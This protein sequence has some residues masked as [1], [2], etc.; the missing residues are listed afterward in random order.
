MRVYFGVALLTIVINCSVMGQ[1]GNQYVRYFDGDSQSDFV[2]DAFKTVEGNVALCG[3]TMINDRS[4]LGFWLVLTDAQQNELWQRSYF[5][6][7]RSTYDIAY[8][9]IQLDDGGYV[10]GGR[11]SIV[12]HLP[13]EFSVLRVDENGEPIW[14]NTYNDDFGSLGN[15]YAVI[16][17]KGGDILAVGGAYVDGD[18]S[19]AV[20]INL[21]GNV[22]WERYFD[23]NGRL[24]SVREI[25]DT[26]FLFAG[27]L[28]T[29]LL[30]LSDR[31]GEVIWRRNYDNTL[32]TLVSSPQG[33]YA[34]A[35]LYDNGLSL[36]RINRDGERLW[37]GHYVSD[38]EVV[39]SVAGTSVAALDDGG[40]IL[41]GTAGRNNPCIIR[42]DAQGNES[43]RRIDHFG[44]RAGIQ[45]EYSS[46]ITP[47]DDEIIVVGTAYNDENGSMDGFL[48]KLIPEIST[49]RIVSFS[50]DDTLIEVLPGEQVLFNVQ[51][52]DWQNDSIRYNWIFHDES[53]SEESACSVQFDELGE[54]HIKCIV[55]DEAV[56]DSIAWY[57]D[58]RDLFITS[59]SP[60]TL[61]LALR[62]GSSQ[63][64]SLDTVRAVEGDPVQYQWTLTDLNTFER[65]ETG[66][67]AS[68]TIEFLRSGN[69]QMEGLAYRGES[70]DN[71]IWTVQV[72]S[73]I[74]DFWPRE[75]HLSVL[76]DSS[77]TFGVLPFNPESDSLSYR[78]E[79]D[80]DS[81]GSD[82]TVTL[83]IAWDDR[84][85]GNPPHLVAAIVMD[86]A[87][88]D[89]VTW[90]V[91]V[92]DP[93]ATPPPPPS[94]EGGEKPNAFGIT[95]VSPNPFNNSTTIRFSVPSGIIS[96]KSAVRLTLHDLTGREVASLVDERAQQAGPYA[97]NFNG[98]D[99]PDGI[100]FL[101]FEAENAVQ[102]KKLA[103]VR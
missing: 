79:V 30:L 21:D 68:A 73:A 56:G 63:T 41:A 94:I 13:G 100:Y 75:L 51:A 35:G 6:A 67:E 1:P 29:G 42:V 81:V 50:P 77:G 19:Y 38:D 2:Y 7:E 18:R 69:Y 43:W 98:K 25:P 66:T 33:G 92:Q 28:G 27:S 5:S 70:S 80:G 17:T 84:R 24:Y 3:S 55:S 39:N 61:S 10:L 103:L 82:S 96:A 26:G 58:V 102:V 46:V 8:S 78:W 88:G 74:L 23:N 54:F 48:V 76:P 64:F 14:W 4:A 36:L 53:V 12:G 85:I 52:A 32:R 95:S 40:F 31:N 22:I 9:I 45:E 72:R 16:E 83:S 57:V 62:R 99:L 91:T 65:E 60:D 59:F 49:P 44:V 34:G 47:Q 101:R 97:I 15:C 11:N 37:Q 71:V 89:T 90:E 86:G 87:E 20:L 93:N